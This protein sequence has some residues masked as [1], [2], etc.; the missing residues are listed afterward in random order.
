SVWVDEDGTVHPN[1]PVLRRV[2]PGIGTLTT[3]E[4][5]LKRFRK[6]QLPQF[7]REYMCRFPTDNATDAISPEAWEAAK[8]E[9]VERPARVGIAFD[10]AYD[11]S[12][13]SIVYAWRDSEGR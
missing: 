7:E 6:M 11:G 4:T 3:L 13:A 9:R 5:I 2:H 1:I 10:C 12:S 8:I